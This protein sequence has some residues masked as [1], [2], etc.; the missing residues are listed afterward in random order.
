MSED[1]QNMLN[2]MELSV[3]DIV[4]GTVTEVEDMNPR[5]FLNTLELF[6]VVHHNARI[7]CSMHYTS[8]RLPLSI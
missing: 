5:Q 3:G 1:L 4:E 2:T 7:V 8:G 6:L